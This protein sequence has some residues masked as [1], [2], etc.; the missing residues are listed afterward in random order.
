[1]LRIE[2]H[3]H[4]RDF[5]QCT[6]FVSFPNETNRVETRYF[7]PTQRFEL[8]VIFFWM[9]HLADLEGH[10]IVE[11]PRIEPPTRFAADV[12]CEPDCL[13]SGHLLWTARLLGGCLETSWL[14]VSTFWAYSL[15]EHAALLSKAFLNTRGKTVA[16]ALSV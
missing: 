16:F 4:S 2:T 12:R 1:M 15:W 7:G 3:H 9:L 13:S 6:S 14:Y 8:F 11:M 5:Q 10:W